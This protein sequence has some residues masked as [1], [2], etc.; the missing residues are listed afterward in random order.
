MVEIG[1]TKVVFLLKLVRT[2][3]TDLDLFD[4]KIKKISNFLLML[5]FLGYKVNIRFR[6]ENLPYSQICGTKVVQTVPYSAYPS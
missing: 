1:N 4:G 6:R 2:L 3:I 5:G